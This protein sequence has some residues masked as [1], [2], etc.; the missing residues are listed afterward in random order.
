MRSGTIDNPFLCDIGAFVTKQETIMGLRAIR[1]I[2]TLFLGLLAAP[3]PGLW[4]HT[5]HH[6]MRKAHVRSVNKGY[7]V[8][9]FFIPFCRDLGC[10]NIF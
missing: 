7:I 3:L 1:L 9:I 5:I 10:I 2:S 6:F 8:T 4:P